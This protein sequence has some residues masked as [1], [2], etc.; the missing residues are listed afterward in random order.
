MIETLETGRDAIARHAWAEAIEAFGAADRDGG[1][2]PEDLGLL[3]KAS[4]WAGQPDDSAEALERAFAGY[5]DVGRAIDAAEVALDLAHQG[6]Q[7]GA[8]SV[9]MGWLARAE[10]LLESQPESRVHAA[11]LAYRAFGELIAT[12]LTEAIDARRPG[13]GGRSPAGQRRCAVLCDG[14]QGHGRSRVRKLESGPAADRRGGD[15][16]R[17]R[18]A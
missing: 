3:G 8:M 13:D 15:G 6:L 4:W 17:V 10:H 11:L 9:A 2:A 7:R 14:V 18:P 1:L 16:R 12:H 5:S